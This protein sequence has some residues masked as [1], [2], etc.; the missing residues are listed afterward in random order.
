[1]NSGLARGDAARVAVVVL[2]WGVAFV[3]I[4]AALRH[5]SPGELAAVRYL[6][7]SAC[8]ALWA[9]AA[10]PRRPARADL[11]RFAV[12]ALV[13]FTTYNLAL[14]TGERSVDA[15]SACLIVN[16]GPIWTAMLSAFLLGERIS[17]RAVA[18]IAVSFTGAALIALAGSGALRWNPDAAW[19]L[20]AAVCQAGYFVTIKPLLSRYTPMEVTTWAMVLGTLAMLPFGGAWWRVLPTA[21]PDALLAVAFLG[22]VAAAL[23][24]V[25]WARVLRGIPAFRAASFLYAVP[26]VSVLAGWLWLGERPQPVTVAGGVLAL[27]G[28]VLVNRERLS[29]APRRG[30]GGT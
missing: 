22:V 14:N 28:V 12:A 26:V 6:L 4:R 30:K 29:R 8:L 21:P 11:P 13:G 7:A 17:L 16:T 25:L 15:A 24:T 1:M 19:I 9:L 2:S 20:L 3:A 5:F 27:A 18:G 23:A 10:K